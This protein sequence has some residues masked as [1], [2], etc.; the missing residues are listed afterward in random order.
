V[1]ASAGKA[2]VAKVEMNPRLRIL[3]DIAFTSLKITVES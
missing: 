3:R 2:M 1:A